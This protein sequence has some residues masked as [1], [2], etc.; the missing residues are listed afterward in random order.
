M[1]KTHVHVR[2]QFGVQMMETFVGLSMLEEHET[3]MICVNTEDL[4]YDGSN[5]ISQLFIPTNGAEIL[6]YHGTRKTPYWYPGCAD[7]V[8]STR[9]KNLNRWFSPKFTREPNDIVAVHIRGKDKPVASYNSY[10]FL[11]SAA[12]LIGDVTIFTDDPQLSS[13]LA[14]EHNVVISN[15]S[16]Q[17]DWVTILNAKAVFCAPSAFI[18]SMLI[19]DPNKTIHMMSEKYC[20]GGFPHFHDDLRFAREAMKHCPNLG[21][22]T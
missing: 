21:V 2:G 13:K 10:S 14:E 5:R 19:I 4:Y 11:I 12:K 8:F 7:S 17:E 16:W 3:P 9:D 15:G 18:M 6:N 22:L 20:D 1:N